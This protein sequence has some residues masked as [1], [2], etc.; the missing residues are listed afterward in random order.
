VCGYTVFVAENGAGAVEKF[1]ALPKS[2]SLVVLDVVMPV[3]GGRQAFEVMRELQPDVRALFMS[4]YSTEI[5]TAKGGLGQG[6][7]FMEKPIIPKI[8]LQKVREILDDRE[9]ESLA[10]R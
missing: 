7:D 4:G 8:F 2:I 3:M 1:A 9:R 5:V 6:Q 10:G